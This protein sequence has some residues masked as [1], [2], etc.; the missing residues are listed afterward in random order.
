LVTFV[1]GCYG[2]RVGVG[3]GGLATC[4]FVL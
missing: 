4:D 3:S 1:V 2:Y